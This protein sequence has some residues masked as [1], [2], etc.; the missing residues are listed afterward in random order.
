MGIIEG[1]TAFLGLLFGTILSGLALWGR[2]SRWLEAYESNR[3]ERFKTMVIE[4][5]KEQGL[6]KNG[7]PQ[8]DW[9]NGSDNMIDFLHV[10]WKSM[11]ATE[12]RL[13][14]LHTEIRVHHGD[15][16]DH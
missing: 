8:D 9:P 10:L 15:D 11:E 7:D 6:I 3:E 14:E 13:H 4:A 16:H 2:I 12:A 1:G 5:I